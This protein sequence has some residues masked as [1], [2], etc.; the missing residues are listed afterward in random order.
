MVVKISARSPFHLFLSNGPRQLS[1]LPLGAVLACL[2]LTACGGDGDAGT[3]GGETTTE[4]VCA[5]GGVTLSDGRCQPAGLPLDM[6]CPPGETPLEDGSCQA[7]GVPPGMCGDGFEADG[8]GGCKPILPEAPCPDGRMAIPGEKE[9]HEVAPC[10]TGTWG[11]IPIEPDTVFV[12]GSYGGNDSDGTQQRPWKAIQE[13]LDAAPSG[14]IVAVAAGTYEEDVQIFKPVRLWGRCPAMVTIHG[15][16]PDNAGV[17]VKASASEIHDVA[18]TGPYVGVYVRGPNDLLI[19]AAWVHDTDGGGVIVDTNSGATVKSS[20]VE[21][22]RFVGIQAQGAT[23]TVERT[24]LRDMLPLKSGSQAGKFGFGVSGKLDTKVR[25][26]VTVRSSLVERAADQAVGTAD[27]DLLVDGVAIRSMT[28]VEGIPSPTGVGLL[29]LRTN[30]TVVGSTIEG[31][32]VAAINIVASE[33]TIERTTVTGTQLLPW[34]DHDSATDIVV[35]QDPKSG[36]PSN[37]TV[38][39]S[40]V[41]GSIGPGIVVFECSALI[42]STLVRDNVQGPGRHEAAIE[43]FGAT[44][45]TIQRSA[46]TGNQWLGLAVD[47]RDALFEESVVRDMKADTGAGGCVLVVPPEAPAAYDSTLKIRSSL[48]EHCAEIGLYAL[49]SHLEV[50]TSIV[51]EVVPDSAGLFGDGV[52]AES[53]MDRA[54]TVA[55]TGVRVEAASRAGVSA[56]GAQID[57]GHTAVSCAK[58]GLAGEAWNGLDFAYRKTGDNVCGCPADQPCAVQTPDL[59]PSDLGGQ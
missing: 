19:D 24:A 26:N 41:A 47:S 16:A 21:R 54:A 25:S 31:A 15:V 37:A 50:E 12:D 59:L 8:E 17:Y 2:C 46:L 4:A 57:I 1:L 39:Q 29:A 35:Q 43:L 6:K 14:V 3:T 9:C 30:A 23:V 53:A 49:S 44:S 27:S 38:R 36:V 32:Y 10:G 13:G 33:A 28:P 5:P 55:L 51:R 40:T 52:T 18:V 20:L 11:D 7:A 58:F 48:F 22:A 42:E 45:A 34:D 56:F